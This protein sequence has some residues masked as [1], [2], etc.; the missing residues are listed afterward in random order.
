MDEE[1]EILTKRM[2]LYLLR[3]P[4]E[5]EQLMVVECAVWTSSQIASHWPRH[6][7]NDVDL[8]LARGMT[9]LALVVGHST[10]VT[11]SLAA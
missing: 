5:K 6:P 8:G 11:F 3:C 1:R 7:L 9:A 2:A 10:S 4:S